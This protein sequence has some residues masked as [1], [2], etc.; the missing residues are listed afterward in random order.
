M[1]RFEICN[2]EY[3]IAFVNAHSYSIKG[4]WYIFVDENGKE[5]TSLS[6]YQVEHIEEVTE[7]HLET[8]IELMQ[9]NIEAL[10]KHV[11][12]LDQNYGELL[13]K[14][15]SLPSKHVEIQEMDNNVLI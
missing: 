1:K 10:I 12:T 9:N 14:V 4:Q 11:K 15:N 8:R 6:K 5:V 13:K 2:S 3:R 7:N